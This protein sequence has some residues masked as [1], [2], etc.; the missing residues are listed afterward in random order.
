MPPKR[1]EGGMVYFEDRGSTY[2]VPIDVLWEFMVTDDEFHPKAH[3]SG[4]RNMKWKDLNEITGGG[5]CEVMRGGKWTKM[6]FRITT[7]RP[8]V[9]IVEEF[10]GRYDGQKMVF[11]YK[12]KGK[13]TAVD[14]LIHTRKDVA[15]EIRL[16]LGKAF[17]EDVPALRKFALKQSGKS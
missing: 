6:R 9:R 13:R 11:L 5:T 7:V 4:L 12:P 15:E 2:D 14:V 10:G 17:E 1:K 8:L 16:T 3:K